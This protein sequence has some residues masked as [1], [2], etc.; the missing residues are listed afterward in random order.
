MASVTRQVEITV[1]ITSEPAALGKLMAVV[2]SCG[3]EVL[4]ACSYWDHAGTVM[5]LVTDDAVRTTRAL[6]AAGFQ[7]RSNPILLIETPD[8]PGLAARLGVKLSAAGI[9]VLHSYAF[10]SD[11]NRSY[12]VF[13]TADDDRA[14][15]LLEV[16]ALIH[17]LA[18]AK[19]W[20]QPV[21]A[22]SGEIRAERHAA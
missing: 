17:E 20:R 1:R 12:V 19:A 13:K 21:T 5:M 22:V 10:R 9:G 15:Y 7:C 8:K 4:A 18:A 3:A 2:G 16:D 14:M 11:R 6:G